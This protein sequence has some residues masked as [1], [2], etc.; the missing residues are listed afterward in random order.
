MCLSILINFPNFIVST[1][2]RYVYVYLTGLDNNC[3]EIK[4]DWQFLTANQIINNII[5]IGK[6]VARR[7]AA[8]HNNGLDE[9]IYFLQSKGNIILIVI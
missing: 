6:G 3:K 9:M 2:N 8:P 5:Y 1:Q 4:N 7:I